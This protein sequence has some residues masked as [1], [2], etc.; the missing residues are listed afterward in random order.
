MPFTLSHAAAVLPVSRALSRWHVL[1]AAVIGCMVP[2]FD[3]LLPDDLADFSRWDT[4]SLPALL[5]FCLPVGLAAYWL[6]QGLIKPAVTE[7]LPAPQRWWMR[8]R[9]PRARMADAGAWL[10]AAAAILF[11]AFTHLVWDTFTHEG[12]RGV[13]MFPLL[14]DYGPDVGG[15]P[16]RLYRWLQHGSSVVGLV[17]VLAALWLWWRRVGR[18]RV[19]ATA[20]ALSGSG[21]SA[22][23]RAAWM[24]A[25]VAVALVPV[26]AQTLRFVAEGASFLGSSEPLTALAVLGLRAAAL[27]LI[28]VSLLLRLRLRNPRLDGS[29]S[30][31]QD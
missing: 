21:L 16:L 29:G 2:D 13:R 28:I 5:F 18:V 22:A 23:E 25:Y 27:S 10:A 19:D 8:E 11:G 14:Q 1:S 20:G 15:H 26:V 4:H 24:I 3:V 9:H 7:I 17:A 31:A 12:S 6:T 30:I